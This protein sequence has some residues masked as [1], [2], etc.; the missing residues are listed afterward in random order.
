MFRAESSVV[1]KYFD[2]AD[3]FVKIRIFT[4]EEIARL[5][6]TNRITDKRSYVGL[7]VNACL[8]HYHDQ[9]LPRVAHLPEHEEQ[10]YGLCVEVNPALDIRKITIPAVDEEAGEIHLFDQPRLLAPKPELQTL[11]DDLARR[12]IGQR[13][14][15]SSV[16]RAIKKSL[17]GL[18]DPQRPVA[19]F[20]FV[21]KTGVGKTELAKALTVLLY[22]DPGRM[23]RVDCSE[24][25]LPHEYA[26]LIGS[27]PGYVG[28]DQP[29]ILARLQGES[30]VL[31][32]E[33]EKSDSKVHNLLLQI[34]DEGFVT[35]N[36]GRRI[37][38]DDAVVILTS[39][40][41]ADEVEEIRNRMGFDAAKRR[42]P[43]RKTVFEETLE[44]LK[45]HFRPEFL[46]RV[47][48]VVLFNPIGI[49]DCEQ[50]ASLMLEEVRKHA[51]N[52]PITV[53][54]SS[55]VPR[56]LAEKGYNPDYGAR[57]IKR[58]VEREIEGP[59]SDLIV[60]GRVRQGDVVAVR[61]QHDKL[62][63]HRN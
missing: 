16:S 53:R 1:Q 61:V 27:P 48:E 6:T 19:T 21:G 13:E 49:K 5:L 46:N 14:A 37:R 9:I 63:F 2:S 17:T 30:I 35:D 24:Y 26:K 7:V 38:F 18:R 33:I 56:Y 59:L 10:L 15:I 8:L 43:D 39:N 22:Q 42:T 62:S 31:F 50:I 12:V 55:Q 34:M 57:E 47:S 11:E 25:A 20:L 41:G 54:F 45:D 29:G 32:D 51:E 28:H 52:V 60:D 4:P 23:V 44:A 58:T 36:K 40:S 3:L